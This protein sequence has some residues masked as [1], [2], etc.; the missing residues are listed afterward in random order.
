M[1]G[2]AAGFGQGM[3][4]GMESQKI[5]LA[6]EKQ[7]AELR[8]AE[9][10]AA[11]ELAAEKRAEAQFNLAQEE[12]AAS[13]EGMALLGQAADLRGQIQGGAAN[14][15]GVPQFPTQPGQPK[16]IMGA[17]NNMMGGLIKKGQYAGVQQ[18][19]EKAMQQASALAGKMNP[20]VADRYLKE[21]ERR[22]LLVADDQA[23]QQ[24]V[25]S[26]SDIKAFGGLTVLDPAG[27]PVQD[28]QLEATL[29]SL[30][31]QA[32]NRNVPLSKLQ[33][34]LDIILGKVNANNTRARTTQFE[35]GT[36]DQSIATAMQANN[37]GAVAALQTARGEFTSNMLLTPQEKSELLSNAQNGLVPVLIGDKKKWV[38]AINKEE[39][40]KKLQAEY[41]DN[42]ALQNR[43]TRAEAALR[44]A[45][46]SYYGRRDTG[47]TLENAQR[48]AI[49]LYNELTDDERFEL[50]QQGITAEDYVNR[51]T[52]NFMS[53][54]GNAEQRGATAMGQTT[55]QV[56]QQAPLPGQRK[57]TIG[58][59]DF[60]VTEEIVNQLQR[61]ADAIGLPKGDA[62]REYA[63]WRFQNQQADPNDFGKAMNRESV[64]KPKDNAPS[65]EAPVVP[66]DKIVN[67]DE[68]QAALA[69]IKELGSKKEKTLQEEVEYLRL[70]KKE[71]EYT[72][73]IEQ[74]S[75]QAQA[76]KAEWTQAKTR[77]EIKDAVWFMKEKRY[78]NYSDARTELLNIPQSQEEFDQMMEYGLSTSG[79]RAYAMRIGLLGQAK[80]FDASKWKNNITIL[81]GR[82]LDA[83][84]EEFGKI[85]K[86][87][88]EKRLNAAQ[89]KKDAEDRKLEQQ[90]LAEESKR[91]M[92]MD[93]YRVEL[94][95]KFNLDIKT[96]RQLEDK[97]SEKEVRLAF[98]ALGN[99]GGTL[100]DLQNY[101]RRSQR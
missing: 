40:V 20:D 33:D 64:V 52:Q 98:A 16:N 25:S 14:M 71:T 93:D 69:R 85:E 27:N 44:E 57:V 60:V 17:F 67:T 38:S 8:F 41:D 18:N 4:L 56:P 81:S 35:L 82:Q 6:R 22:N 84:K 9:Q 42:K 79:G 95:K 1:A 88:N 101:L 37:G 53:Q 80:G 26:L 31:E 36:I 48:N 68:A 55:G 29:R 28:P 34:Q 21:V 7:E 12:R 39:E 47:M 54:G 72:T 65:T 83:A 91:M 49:R 63:Q 32:D 97:Y 70:K 3:Q 43:L 23:R 46:S 66:T 99:K 100:T 45:Q 50:Q 2:L 77:T 87:E 59:K 74:A 86:V 76:V 75:K 30:V 15:P 51:V 24:F 13:K 19:Y 94:A 89:P 58:S 96:V 62:R 11:S 92:S 61:E 78:G 90:R 5:Q 10:R 73:Q